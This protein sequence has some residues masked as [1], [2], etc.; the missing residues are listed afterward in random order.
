LEAARWSRSAGRLAQLGDTINGKKLAK[1][2]LLKVTVG[3]MG[4]TRSFN[5]NAQIV[6][7]ANFTDK[8]NAIITTEVP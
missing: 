5:N 8:S 3:N 2:T 6:W 1:F 7:L 4:V